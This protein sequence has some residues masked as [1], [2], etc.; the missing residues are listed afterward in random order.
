MEVPKE[1]KLIKE[2]ETKLIYELKG[3]GG[4]FKRWYVPKNEN[5]R[6]V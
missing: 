5:R 2:T 1:A 6:K 4:N 3:T